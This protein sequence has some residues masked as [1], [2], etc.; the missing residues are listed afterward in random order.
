MKKTILIASVA[1]L[2]AVLV[3]T[4]YGRREQESTAPGTVTQTPTITGNVIAVTPQTSRAAIGDEVKIDIISREVQNVYGVQISVMYD[5][6]VLEFMKAEEGTFLSK[7][8]QENTIY[9]PSVMDTKTNGLVKDFVLVKT[10]DVGTSG[11]GVIGTLT[12]KA[13]TAG[14]AAVSIRTD[15]MISNSDAK[16]I[17]VQTENSQVVIG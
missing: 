9:M 10:G 3:I 1:V 16:P 4:M 8:G 17:V 2:I 14:T 6:Q 11:S 13:K 5:S 12:F 15:S 7:N